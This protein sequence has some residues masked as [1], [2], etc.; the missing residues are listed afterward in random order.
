[1]PAP[2]AASR[3]L[4]GSFEQFSVTR[5]FL[6]ESLVDAA[7]GMFAQPWIRAALSPK[8]R[9]L[10][11]LSLDASASQLEPS[12]LPQRID[13]ARSE[14]ATDREIITVLHLTTLMACHSMSVGGTILYEVL[15]ER[16]EAASNDALTSEQQEAV[17]HYEEDGP[18]RRT[19][20]D[21]L[22]T[23]MLTDTLHFSKMQSYI[24]EAY[25]ATD[26]ISVKFAHLICLAFDV[27]PTHL[28]EAG[29]RIHIREA[30]DHGATT[31][32]IYE[33]FQLASLRGWRSMVSGLEALSAKPPT[34]Q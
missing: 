24:S 1:L 28:F 23:I 12:R 19:I 6:G 14:G 4:F 3:E 15:L 13:D 16:G 11:L 33:V 26:A 2:D 27:A 20:S 10:I 21:R 8:E 17:R 30:L 25:G 22:R 9:A 32:E 34:S 31:A 29:I 7:I 5:E 18:S